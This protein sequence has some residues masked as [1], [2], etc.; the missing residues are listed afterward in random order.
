[1]DEKEYT[2]F[3]EQFWEWYDNLLPYQRAVLM[4]YKEDIAETR[5]Y[6]MKW[7]KK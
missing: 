5:F 2:K 6:F 7:K 3:K 4:Y 1:M